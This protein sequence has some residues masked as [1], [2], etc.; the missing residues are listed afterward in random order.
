M[1]GS[2]C[3]FL[4][5]H[6]LVWVNAGTI[7]KF[8]QVGPLITNNAKPAVS[9]TRQNFTTKLK[10]NR[11]NHDCLGEDALVSGTDYKL[12]PNNTHVDCTDDGLESERASL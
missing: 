5:L 2:F 10:K 4:S 9:P 6:N 8:L 3:C 7:A 1:D 11:S 12:D